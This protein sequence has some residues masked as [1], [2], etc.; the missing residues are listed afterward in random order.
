MWRSVDSSVVM[1]LTIGG[2]GPRQYRRDP[3]NTS[4]RRVGVAHQLLELGG[5][6]GARERGTG[7]G[8]GQVVAVEGVAGV[9][10]VA[11]PVE[12]LA[13][14]VLDGRAGAVGLARGLDPDVGVD[15]GGRG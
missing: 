15:P 1:D 14:V 4:Q 3:R 9:R 5:E 8:A 12:A 6:P 7:Q 10:R 11:H 13:V 2:G